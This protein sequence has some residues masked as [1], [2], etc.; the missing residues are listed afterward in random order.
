[1]EQ[2]DAGFAD[3]VP[4]ARTPSSRSVHEHLERLLLNDRELLISL[5]CQLDQIRRQVRLLSDE[6]MVRALADDEGSSVGH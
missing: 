3:A 1:M 2:P 4:L 6:R 5:H